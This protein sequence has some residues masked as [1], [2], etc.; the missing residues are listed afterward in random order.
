MAVKISPSKLYE[1]FYSLSSNEGSMLQQYIENLGQF[2]FT[3][4]FA[5]LKIYFIQEAAIFYNTKGKFFVEVVKKVLEVENKPAD[6]I[7]MIINYVAEYFLGI[8]LH[9]NKMLYS[10]LTDRSEK[11]A[12]LISTG[13][14]LRFIGPP[15]ASTVCFKVMGLLK[16]TIK[17]EYN[18]PFK[19]L[20]IEI[21]RIL[22]RT[23]DL[24]S[25]GPFLSVLFVGIEPYIEDFP[26]KV[27]EICEFL[28]HQNASTLSIHISDLFF[29]EKLDYSD[30]I[31]H[32]ILSQI[33]S[34]SLLNGNDIQTN[35]DRLIRHMNSENAD[36]DVKFYCLQYLHQFSKNNRKNLNQLIFTPMKTNSIIADLLCVLIDC[37]RTA[38]EKLLIQTGTCLG[39]IGALAPELHMPMNN[40]SQNL[41]FDVYNDNFVVNLLNILFKYYKDLQADNFNNLEALG[42]AIQEIIRERSIAQRPSDPIWSK[43]SESARLIMKPLFSSHYSPI[44]LVVPT[45]DLIFWNHAQ[46][47][48]DWAH[49]LSTV[50]IESIKNS[51]VQCFFNSLNGNTRF[52]DEI[53]SLLLPYIILHYFSLNPTQEINDRIVKEFNYVFDIIRGKRDLSLNT[54]D[55]ACRVLGRFYLKIKIFI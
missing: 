37:S 27:D 8:M 21:W 30:E 13:E 11:E 52:Y 23:C 6:N 50:L 24:S 47:S 7:E 4:L 34:Q 54:S 44:N 5:Q 15:H 40:F 29:I 41:G 48:A 1:C 32:T 36:S 39:E 55:D 16:S 12:A 3:E 28:L 26:E 49:S 46:T 38:N 43:L 31:K 2:T 14:L 20:Y 17:K 53:A 10:E 35:L 25:L 19:R 45:N 18:Q 51:D 42:A 33:A 22:I 9:F